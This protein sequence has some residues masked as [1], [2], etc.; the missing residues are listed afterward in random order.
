MSEREQMMTEA[1]VAELCQVHVQTVRRWRRDGTGPPSL[2]LGG[3]VRYDPT[4]VRE[5]LREQGERK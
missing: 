5:W 2:R 1:Q 3:R 4:S